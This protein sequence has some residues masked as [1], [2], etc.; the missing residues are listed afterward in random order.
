MMLEYWDRSLKNGGIT[1]DLKQEYMEVYTRERAS[2]PAYF[3][4]TLM[5]RNSRV[6]VFQNEHNG[7]PSM[8]IEAWLEL[9]GIDWQSELKIVE[10]MSTKRIVGQ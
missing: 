4:I 9:Q 3:R 8:P 10:S 7:Q 5:Q 2:E 1:Y 6:V